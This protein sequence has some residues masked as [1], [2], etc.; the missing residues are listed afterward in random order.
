MKLQKDIELTL[1]MQEKLAQNTNGMYRRVQMPKPL[2]DSRTQVLK[3]IGEDMAKALE[4]AKDECRKSEKALM[5]E[6]QKV[7]AKTNRPMLAN[8]FKEH[9]YGQM[10]TLYMTLHDNEKEHLEAQTRDVG[11]AA[12]EMA[13]K[14]LSDAQI[15][16]EDDQEIM[17]TIARAM[18]VL[19]KEIATEIDRKRM[20]RDGNESDLTGVK[21]P[22]WML[23]L[24]AI[25][26]VVRPSILDSAAD[27]GGMLEL[28]KYFGEMHGG[29]LARYIQNLRLSMDKFEVANGKI[30]K[31]MLVRILVIQV[32]LQ[33]KARWLEDYRTHTKLD[34]TWDLDL[35]DPSMIAGKYDEAVSKALKYMR[36]HDTYRS[37][38]M[39]HVPK[40]LAEAQKDG[41]SDVMPKLKKCAMLVTQYHKTVIDTQEELAT[42]MFQQETGKRCPHCNT[43]HDDPTECTRRKLLRDTLEQLNPLA[44][45]ITEISEMQKKIMEGRTLTPNQ[46][47]SMD[48]AVKV[49]EEI[50]KTIKNPPKSTFKPKAKGAQPE[51]GECISH[52]RHGKCKFGDKCRYLHKPDR[53]GTDP[54]FLKSPK[55]TDEDKAAPT[56]ATKDKTQPSQD[57]DDK[58]AACMQAD[59]Q[60]E[61]QQATKASMAE[62]ARIVSPPAPSNELRAYALTAG[63]GGTPIQGKGAA[64]VMMATMNTSSDNNVYIDKMVQMEHPKKK[65]KRLSA[66]LRAGRAYK[67]T[68]EAGK[69]Y[70]KVQHPMLQSRPIPPNPHAN[71]MKS[72]F[73]GHQLPTEKKSAATEFT[74]H[75]G[76]HTIAVADIEMKQVESMKVAYRDRPVPN[77]IERR[78]HGRYRCGCMLT[79]S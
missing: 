5:G 43:I 21:T 42:V 62:I 31:E 1:K 14:T 55:Q 70:K 52:V 76:M 2:G 72:K 34:T 75:D 49:L 54:D 32:I 35:D 22:G 8:A 59:L 15:G 36:T 64:T 79:G 4:A 39:Q 23:L 44:N 45:K 20:D 3:S 28:P 48:A 60:E 66:K 33:G 19:R 77:G 53:A 18:T 46:N 26:M 74:L 69:E 51:K 12:A 61:I 9:S 17:V 38:V 11:S 13:Q 56:E 6:I 37:S 78:W 67:A 25:Q 41:E 57:E 63:L 71:A 73:G 68:S 40:T 29:D 16:F 47:K 65:R 50:F 24:T 7:L 30:T 58:D 10:V 27:L